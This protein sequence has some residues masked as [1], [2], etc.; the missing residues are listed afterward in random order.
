MPYCVLAFDEF[1]ALILAG[2]EEKK[3]FERDFQR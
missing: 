2:K 3:E 1:A